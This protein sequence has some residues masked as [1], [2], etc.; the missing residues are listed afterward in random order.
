LPSVVPLWRNGAW[1]YAALV[2]GVA[3]LALGFGA[4]FRHAVRAVRQHAGSAIQAPFGGAARTDPVTGLPTAGAFRAG[5]DANRVIGGASGIFVLDVDGFRALRDQHGS[6][7][8]DQLLRDIAGRMRALMP[9]GGFLAH[10]H[11]DEFVLTAP[12]LNEGAVMRMAAELGR[13]L[14][15]PFSVDGAPS[16]LSISIGA[17]F[18]PAAGPGADHA[19]RAGLLAL[20]QAKADGGGTWRL[21][22]PDLAAAAEARTTLAV[23]FRRALQADQIVPFYQPIVALADGRVLGFEVLARWQHPQR[24]LLMPDQFIPLAEA[25]RLCAELSLCLL[26][27][28]CSDARYWPASWNFAFNA[29]PGQLPELLAFVADP[30]RMPSYMLNPARITLELTE[31]TLIADLPMARRVVRA[32]HAGGARVALDDFGTGYANFLHLREIPV[33]SLKIDRSFTKDMLTDSRTEA[34]VRAMLALGASLGIDVVAEGVET[35]AQA[36]RLRQMGCAYA[37]GYLFSRPVPAAAMAR[38]LPGNLPAHMAALV[39]AN[40]QSI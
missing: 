15:E 8:A 7:L 17:A 19:V 5:M 40:G 18:L 2:L 6:A 26:R 32:M 9:S 21:Y 33:D 27:Q 39:P 37:Q 14:A 29:T 3:A 11:G 4:Q 13:G 22:D 30:A 35:Q 16:K 25:H 36:D 28:V 23:E 20:Q 38:F 31:T 12:G 10:L 24:G 34:C 1:P